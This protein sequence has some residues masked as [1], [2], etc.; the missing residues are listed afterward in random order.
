MFIGDGAKLVRDCFALARRR[1]PP[2]LYRR[3]DADRYQAFRLR[4]RRSRSAAKAGTPGW[5]TALP[6]TTIKVWQPTVMLDPAFPVVWTSSLTAE[7]G[8]SRQ[9]LTQ[10]LARCPSVSTGPSW[11]WHDEFGE[12]RLFVLRLYGALEGPEQDW[13]RELRR[14]Y[15]RG[16][17]K[18]D[19]NMGIYV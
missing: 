6:R 14:C 13:S 15:R 7:R 18:E 12:L 11:L 1:R 4:N 9:H 5:W 2:S 19:T 17:A 16:Q 3:L 8:S 10:V